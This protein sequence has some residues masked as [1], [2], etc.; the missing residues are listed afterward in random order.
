MPS[1]YSP[2]LRLEL[3]GNG[4]QAG[5][6]GTTTNK[7]LGTLLE[8]SIAGVKA[9]TMF[10]ATYTL[11]ALSGVT[12]EARQAVLVVS[13]T[14]SAIRAVVAPLAVKTYTIVNNTSGGF[15]ITIG[16]VSGAVVTVPSGATMNVYCDGTKFVEAKPYSAT[17][18]AGLSTTL[19]VTSGGTGVTTSTGSG[20]TVRSITPTLV[21]PLLGTPTSGVLTNCTGL[22]IAT[23][24]TG[25]AAGAATFLT[26]PTS[27][28]LKALVTDE[29]GSGAL[30][31]ATSPTLVTPV[32]GT[33]AS[34]V[35][36]NC[37][38]K[39]LCKAF[40]AFDGNTGTIISSLN[41]TSVTRSGVGIYAVNMTT[42]LASTAYTIVTG[43]DDASGQSNTIN[44]GTTRTVSSFNMGCA[45]SN[46][47][48]NR[49]A[50]YIT[51]A[52]FA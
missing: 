31:F 32:L 6:W 39:N 49:D 20:A 43:Y 52:V 12:D 14:N 25:A 51:A 11:S 34:G 38:G 41:V 9:I 21:T 40:V 1:T 22:P 35:L 13:G 37:T 27:A 10:N 4:E 45:N 29:V 48:A 8:Q 24:I 23:G 5:S 16:A 47:G 15:A 19:A 18:A 28:N 50:D 3:I 30:V 17:V 33:P 44:A 26:T 42:A 2:S 7:N 36:T 46:S